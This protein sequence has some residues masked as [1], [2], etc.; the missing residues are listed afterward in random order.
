MRKEHW[1]FSWQ[2]W[3]L[4][5]SVGLMAAYFAFLNIHPFLAV[6]HRVN[7]KIVVVEGWIHPYAIR[8]ATEEFKRGSYQRIFATVGPVARSGGYINDYNTSA[9]VSADSLTKAGVST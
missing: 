6:T 3:L 5:I 7:T 4:A 8:A 2:G 1:G 9:S